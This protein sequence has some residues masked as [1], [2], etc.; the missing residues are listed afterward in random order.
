MTIVK[1]LLDN[2]HEQIFR[3]NLKVL[4]DGLFSISGA[5]ICI[6][7]LFKGERKDEGDVFIG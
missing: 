3:Q 2:C 5:T 1:K 6:Y 7:I 4:K